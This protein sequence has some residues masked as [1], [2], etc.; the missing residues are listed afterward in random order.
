VL[1]AIVPDNLNHWNLQGP[2]SCDYTS[3]RYHR[4]QRGQLCKPADQPV[5]IRRKEALPIRGW[6][7]EW[8]S[9]KVRRK[10]DYVGYQAFNTI[11]IHNDITNSHHEGL[12]LTSSSPTGLGAPGRRGQVLPA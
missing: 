2:A 10:Y 11:G 7:Q 3:G 12:L 1:S 9:R 6:Q 8:A 4:S 5:Q